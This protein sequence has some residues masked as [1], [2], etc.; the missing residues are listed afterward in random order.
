MKGPHGRAE[1]AT[2]MDLPFLFGFVVLALAVIGAT[3]RLHLL[4]ASSF[5]WGF[6][7]PEREQSERWLR[8]ID[9][10]MVGIWVAGTVAMTVL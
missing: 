10:A 5:D 3:L 4:F 9:I 6:P 2:Q 8:G 1:G 7:A